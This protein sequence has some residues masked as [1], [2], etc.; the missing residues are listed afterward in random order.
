MSFHQRESERRTVAI[1]IVPYW[2]LWHWVDR[3]ASLCN[4]TGRYDNP[5]PHS[6]LFP[7]VGDYMN[8]AS[9]QWGSGLCRYTFVLPQTVTPT[10]PL[11]PRRSVDYLQTHSDNL[12]GAFTEPKSMVFTHENIWIKVE[13][14]NFSPSVKHKEITVNDVNA[15]LQQFKGTVSR[16][17]LLLVFFLNQFP[18]SLWLYH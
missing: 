7:P 8:W 13:N 3:P 15:L 5:K 12:A 14:H 17:F 16:D 9:C 4:L 1:F 2:G 11:P 6:T 18:P 10:T